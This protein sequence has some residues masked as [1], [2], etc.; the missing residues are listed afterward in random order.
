MIDGI[1][2]ARA[3]GSGIDEVTHFA[4]KRRNQSRFAHQD[5]LLSPVLAAEFLIEQVKAG[6][7]TACER[8]KEIITMTLDPD[9]EQR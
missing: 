4:N 9:F 5:C 2:F 3:I 1:E 6:N 8:V 7:Y